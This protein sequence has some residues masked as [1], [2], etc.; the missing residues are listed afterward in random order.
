[1]KNEKMKYHIVDLRDR[2]CEKVAS[3]KY[4]YDRDHAFAVLKYGERGYG[5]FQDQD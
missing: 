3:F 5:K 2:R 4:E 1:M